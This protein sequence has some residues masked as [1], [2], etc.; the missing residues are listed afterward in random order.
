VFDNYGK[1]LTKRI[2]AIIE[3]RPKNVKGKK[4]AAA[5]ADRNKAEF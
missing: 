1:I 2:K 4:A 5:I 3:S